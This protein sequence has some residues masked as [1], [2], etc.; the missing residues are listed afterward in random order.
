MKRLLGASSIV[1]LVENFIQDNQA[2]TA[3]LRPKE[4]V[5]LGV[6]LATE[7]EPGYH[8]LNLEVPNG[9]QYNDIEV[10]TAE[11]NQL[12]FPDRDP[13]KSMMIVMSSM[14]PIRNSS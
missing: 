5:S 3:V 4:G 12:L 14:R 2:V 1:V 13:K 8:L 9:V 7:N 6:G 11:A 10:M